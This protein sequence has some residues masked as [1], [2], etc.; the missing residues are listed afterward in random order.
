MFLLLG[1][2]SEIGAAAYRQPQEEG[3]SV[4][5]TTRRLDTVSPE[6]PYFD[7]LN[8]LDELEPAAGNESGM[9]FLGGREVARLC[10]RPRRV[11]SD[12]RNA[13]DSSR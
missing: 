10:R 9:H 11:G 12:Q 2:D 1:G 13:I 3:R 7:I 4:I 5:A 8:T 6:R